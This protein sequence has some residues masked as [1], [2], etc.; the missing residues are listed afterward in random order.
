MISFSL[1]NRLARLMLTIRHTHA[2]TQV[3]KYFPPESDDEYDDL[4]LIKYED[5]DA[6]HLNV[7]E[8]SSNK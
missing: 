1:G 7:E 6:E 4:W 2:Y 8:V 3:V 5:G